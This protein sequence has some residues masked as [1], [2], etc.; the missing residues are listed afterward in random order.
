[1]RTRRSSAPSRRSTRPAT[2]SA[3]SPWSSSRSRTPSRATS[4]SGRSRGRWFSRWWWRSDVATP[5]PHDDEEAG[6]RSRRSSRGLSLPNAPGRRL[7]AGGRALDHRHRPAGRSGS[8]TLVALALPGQGRLT[9]WWRDSIVPFFGAGR[10]ILPFAL[11]VAGWYVEWGPGKEAKAPWGRHPRRPGC[12][13]RRL[14]RGHPDP[15]GFG[16]DRDTGGL[17]WRERSSRSWSRW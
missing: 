11:L 4:T 10:F 8:V 14:P 16:A 13:V 7:R 2:T 12:R 1:M 9:D 17:D 5:A 3:R 15:P 6:P